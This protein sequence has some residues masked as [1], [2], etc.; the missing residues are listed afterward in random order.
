LDAVRALRLS[1]REPAVPFGLDELCDCGL[2]CRGAEVSLPVLYGKSWELNLLEHETF[3]HQFALIFVISRSSWTHYF[4]IDTKFAKVH[5]QNV[6]GR[7]FLTK[8][9]LWER[10]TTLQRTCK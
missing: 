9:Q 3:L 1:R 10:S 4:P 8:K 6:Q 5:G 7:H 2:T